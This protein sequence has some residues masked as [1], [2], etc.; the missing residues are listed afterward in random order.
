MKPFLKTILLLISILCCSIPARAAEVLERKIDVVFRQTPL[1]EALNII[2]RDAGFEWSYNANILDGSRKTSLTANDWTVR[3]TLYEILGEG[4]EFKQNGNYLILKKRR[5]PPEQLSGYVKDP[6]NGKRLANVTVY[7]RQTLRATTTDSNGYYELKVKKN[8][9][10]VVALLDYR[11]TI[12]P[13][14]R[15]TP[16]FQKI[17]LQVSPV[18]KPR[19]RPLDETLQIAASEAERFFRAT[20][21]KWNLINVQD[22]LH[23]RYQISFLPMLGT[24]HTLSGK[25]VNDWSFNILSG[26]SLGNRRLEIAG[27]SNFTRQYVSGVQV[28][29]VFNEL[30]GDLHGVQVAGMYNRCGDTLSGLQIGGL[31]NVARHSAG[32]ASQL[33]GIANFSRS[34]NMFAQVSGVW[35]RLNGNMTGLQLSAI[36]NRTLDTLS[37]IQ[38]AGIVN[39]TRMVTG[40]ASQVAGIANHAGQ[41]EVQLQIAGIKNTAELVELLQVAGIVNKATSVRGLQAVGIVNKADSVR[42]LQV[43]GISNQARKVRGIQIGLFNSA[44]DIKGLQIGLI[45]RSGRRVLPLLNW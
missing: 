26:V 20:L 18:E 2:A 32:V 27:I 3:E 40:V 16:R 42:G 1:K 9:E 39:K 8:T 24:N 17:E 30:H 36:C 35:N 4:Y 43:A 33:G 13:V 34:G 6:E 28:A 22:S 5:K 23:R 14:T 44:Q 15:Q 19:A 45:N 11:D 25:V 41:G 29:G 37:G 21:E 38:V 7:D 12:F 31:V 10:I